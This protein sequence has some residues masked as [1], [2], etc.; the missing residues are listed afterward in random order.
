MAKE[1]RKNELKKIKKLY[2][3]FSYQSLSGKKKKFPLKIKFYI[4]KRDSWILI[5]KN[6]KK[7]TNLKIND[8]FWNWKFK[9]G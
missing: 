4:R 5:S 1:S 2:P 3:M 6:Y 9:L 7:L 8:K